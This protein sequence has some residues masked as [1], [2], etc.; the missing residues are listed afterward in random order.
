MGRKPRIEI[1]RATNKEYFLTVKGS[2]NRK[3]VTSGETYQRRAGVEHAVE[4]LKKI[5]PTA[6]VEDK[7]KK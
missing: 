1:N 6:K 7:T 2:N 4:L 3:I 5:M